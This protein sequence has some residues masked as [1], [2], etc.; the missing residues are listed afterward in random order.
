[1]QVSIETTSGLGRRLIVGVP[2]ERVE[3]EVD[4][5]LRRAAKK[6][7]LDGFRPGKVPMKVV[8]Q[9]FGADVRREVQ[10]EVMNESFNE[11]ISQENIRPASRPSIEPRTLEEGK[12]LEFVATFEV[13][14]EI[15]LVDM[16]R[17]KITRPK[18]E[19]S[20]KDVDEM[21]ELFRK[22]QGQW[23]SVKRAAADGD[24]ANIDY[25]GT[26]D[27]EAFEGG[28]AQGVD[29]VL[30]ANS[31]IPGFEEGIVGMGIGE[32]KTLDLHFP[33]DYPSE[34][35]KGR[36]VQFKIT[37]NTVSENTPAPMDE[38]LFRKYGVEEGGDEQFRQEIRENMQRELT[39]AIRASVRK[40]VL[41]AL[42][43]AHKD[44]DVP[45]ALV[46][47][48]I[49][50]RRRRVLQSAGQ[51]DMG[52][53]DPNTLAE[54]LPAEQFEKQADRD[55]RVSML[56]SEFITRNELV[57]DAGRVAEYIDKITA[58]YEEPEQVARWYHESE[59]QMN[60]VRSIVLQDQVID[61]LL[62]SAKIRDKRCS[63]K[64]AIA[65]ARGN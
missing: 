54:I 15:R 63:Y 34:D 45:R 40:Q 46:D 24:R 12:D 28:T 55:V 47:A 11:A 52:Q 19:V 61:N 39:D 13:Y 41:D 10:G 4:T 57:A 65:Q 18:A 7:R 1:M 23:E 30:G 43:E 56:V 5:R 21:V 51:S 2:A 42:Y 48:E 44:Q 27:G 37:L 59:E 64:D 14:P 36:E 35:L 33:D 29:L 49:N 9:R 26:R 50:A 6:V 3:R 38:E 25:A 17:M 60:N 8:R 16:S 32:E 20:D 53:M 31:M 62:E 58:T 22:Q